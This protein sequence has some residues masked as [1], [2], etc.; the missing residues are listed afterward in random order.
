MYK[1]GKKNQKVK[2][3]CTNF[4]YNIFRDIKLNIPVLKHLPAS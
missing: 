3:N 4:N 2:Q 1:L